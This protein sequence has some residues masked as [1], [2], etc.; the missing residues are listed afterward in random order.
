MKG[1]AYGLCGL[2]DGFIEDDKTIPD[3]SLAK[4]AVEFGDAWM[5]SDAKE[6]EKRFCPQKIQEIAFEACSVLK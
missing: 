2:Y 4:T 3:G 1:K 5:N 6:C